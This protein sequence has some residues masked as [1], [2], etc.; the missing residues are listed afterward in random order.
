MSY[1][2]TLPHFRKC[3]DQYYV[4]FVLDSNARDEKKKFVPNPICTDVTLTEQTDLKYL[5]SQ[6]PDVNGLSLIVDDSKREEQLST[7]SVEDFLEPADHYDI[8]DYYNFIENC[9]V[10]FRSLPAAVR[11]KYGDNPINLVSALDADYSGTVA[12]MEQYF[13]PL[14][15]QFDSTG[16]P[17]VGSPNPEVSTP[18]NLKENEK[19]NLDI[20]TLKDNKN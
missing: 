1:I 3:N 20:S 10:K 11:K 18:S 7:I 2:S 16:T 8:F 12:D 4:S 5:F 13:K 14:G 9:K 15:L 6:N 17:P 19:V